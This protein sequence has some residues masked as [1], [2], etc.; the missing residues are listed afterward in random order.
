MYPTESMQIMM[1][2]SSVMMVSTV[3]KARW[4]IG[5]YS[6]MRW[7]YSFSRPGLLEVIFV[8]YLGAERKRTGILYDQVEAE[9]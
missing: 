4:L 7:L 3:P 5:Y 6:A 9:K 2:N 1:R 8:R